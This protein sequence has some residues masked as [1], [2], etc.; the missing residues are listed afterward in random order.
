MGMYFYYVEYYDEYGKTNIA[1]GI[2][3]G[4]NYVNALN[5]LT[6]Y[7]GEEEISKL[8]LEYLSDKPLVS[9]PND[10]LNDGLKT[11]IFSDNNI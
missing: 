9:F 2:V 5:N 10:T 4:T 8:T 3:C 6:E 1:N 11:I 7:Y